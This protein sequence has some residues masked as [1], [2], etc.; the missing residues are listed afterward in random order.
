MFGNYGF[1]LRN[2]RSQIFETHYQCYS[3]AMAGKSNLDEGDKI[4]LPPSAL[5]TLSRMEVEYPMLF[6]LKNERLGR[7]T[8]CGVIEFIAEEG[9]CHLPRFMMQSLLVEEGSII[10]IKNVSL[11]K[12]SYVKFR[13]TSVDFLEIS[14]PRAVLEYTLRKYTCVTVGDQVVLHHLGKLHS[15]DVQEV[16]PDGA[17]SIV[18]TD[19]EIDFDEPIGFKE[20]KYA[21]KESKE[22]VKISE[23]ENN[24]IKTQTLQKARSEEA[25]PAVPEF[26]PFNGAGK[27]IDG[28]PAPLS[29]STQK[30]A[31]VAVAAP[32]AIVPPPA[33]DTT[34]Q[35]KYQSRIG[36]KYSTK[37][38]NSSAF[39]GTAHKLN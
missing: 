30:P 14:N 22:V 3:M 31:P 8:H 17:A 20:S 19:V 5:N 10:Y 39:T 38:V 25:K 9:S 37:K 11:K 2:N 13:A 4:L 28:K 15:F 33:Q 35:V 16:R 36:D 18:E 27:R 21:K 34:H 26:K 1:D 6:E 7:K 23:G 24:A 32:T 29:S 12:A